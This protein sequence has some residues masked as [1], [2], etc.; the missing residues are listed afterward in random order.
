MKR[1]NESKGIEGAKCVRMGKQQV[2]R[3]STIVR[4]PRADLA[5]SNCDWRSRRATPLKF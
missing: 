2:Q 4:V 1:T 5:K 3:K